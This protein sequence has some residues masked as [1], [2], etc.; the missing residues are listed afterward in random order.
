VNCRRER[1]TLGCLFIDDLSRR[2]GRL[3]PPVIPGVEVRVF[4]C[5]DPRDLWDRLQTDLQVVRAERGGCAVVA[6]GTGCAAALALACQL[7]VDKLA[8][9]DPVAPDRPS[10]RRIPAE[11]PD[12][13]ALRRVLRRLAAFARRNLPL[14]VCDLLIVEHGP[15]PGGGGMRRAYGAPVNCRTQ[16]LL[17]PEHSGRE[18]YTIR[19]FEVKEAIS[20]F[21][22]PTEATKPLAE[23]S[24]M[25]IIYG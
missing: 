3:R 22:H 18:L 23:N 5:T 2:H 6:S 8:L 20:R 25:C 9:I 10:L 1:E 15:G 16:T 12:A 4:C 11:P 17:L 19:E 21:L 14:C 7:P 13:A 24:E